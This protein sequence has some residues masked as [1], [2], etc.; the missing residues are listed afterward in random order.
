MTKRSEKTVL[1]VGRR[2]TGKSTLTRK[3][4]EATGKAVLCVDTF[5][6]PAYRSYQRLTTEELHTMKPG[7]KY[8]IFGGDTMA[9]IKSIFTDDVVYDCSVI[10][11][12]AYKVFD[13]Q[14]PKQIRAGLIDHRNKGIDLFVIYHA[15]ADVAPYIAR[16]YDLC[17]MFKT[18][19]KLDKDLDK[20]GIHW[21]KIVHTQERVR[22]VANQYYNQTLKIW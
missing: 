15:F 2:E 22:A 12:D 21:E 9:N 11:E 10:I 18:E 5:D 8:R 20:F 14:L 13:S 6:H 19:D 17:V 4:A 16:M 7:K 1:I 3:L